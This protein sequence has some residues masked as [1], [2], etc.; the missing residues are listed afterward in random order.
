MN[1]NARKI[2]FGIVLVLIGL[3]LL[4]RTLGLVSSGEMGRMIAAFC[5]IALG[6]YLILRR[7][8]KEF[9]IHV[10]KSGSDSSPGRTYTWSSSGSASSFTSDAGSTTT[11]NERTF[12]DDK[13]KVSEQP[14]SR[15]DGD[16][17]YSKLFGDMFI[18]AAGVG[19]EN[20]EISAGIGD[21]ELR[22]KGARLNASL[23][24]I[25]ISGFIGDV[26]VYVPRDMAYSATCSNFI[27]DVE[28][29]GKNATGFGNNISTFSTDYDTAPQKLY[30]AANSFIGDIRVVVVD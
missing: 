21:L 3:L 18:D 11:K 25:V 30:I 28:I 17:R 10:Q 26:R 8:H 5:L 16:L 1:G 4:A 2:T 24:R 13:T 6:I 20:I 15:T 19:F 12:G 27:G 22:L 14:E 9:I 23:N 7:R 29:A